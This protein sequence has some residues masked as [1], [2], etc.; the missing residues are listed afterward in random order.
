MYGRLCTN[1]SA[2]QARQLKRGNASPTPDAALAPHQGADSGGMPSDGMR[3]ETQR[4]AAAR[5]SDQVL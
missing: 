2:A 3:D 5:R 4:V 1:P